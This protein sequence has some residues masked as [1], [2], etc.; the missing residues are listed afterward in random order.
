[1]CHLTWVMGVL[2]STSWF[3]IHL[4]IVFVDVS[5]V[6]RMYCIV[7]TSVRD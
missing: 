7:F 2:S 1:M 4:F 6:G 3:I 5:A